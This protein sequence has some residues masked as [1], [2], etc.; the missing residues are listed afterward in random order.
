MSKGKL[1]ITRMEKNVLSLLFGNDGELMQIY[2]DGGRY[3]SL[4]GNIYVGR[5]SNIVESINGAFVE[6]AHEKTGY[7]ALEDEKNPIFTDINRKEA[8]I[9]NG[10][11][12]I[13]Q[14]TKDAAGNKEPVVS[15]N[16]TLTG[17]YVV[18]STA[19]TG[20][21]FSSKFRNK[22]KIEKI[23][24]KYEELG[25]DGFGFIIRTNAAK[26][27]MDSIFEEIDLY[28]QLWKA[29]RD[30]AFGKKGIGQIYSSPK[31]YIASIRDGYDDDVSSII[32]DNARIYQEI[33]DYLSVYQTDDIDKLSLYDNP[34]VSLDALYS[35]SSH[36]ND[37]LKER[38]WLKSGGYLIIQPTEAFVSIDVNTGKYVSKKDSQKEFL[39]INLEAAEEIAKQIRLRNLSGIIIIDFINMKSKE[40]RDQLMKEFDALLKKDPQKT[41]LV[42]MTKLNLVEI[43]RKKERRPL[44]E[45]LDI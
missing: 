14:V 42:E 37:A 21:H 2:C 32:T 12:L 19:S 26:A 34:Y 20:L 16:I 13:V 27:P 43:T 5:V 15:T 9:K 4:V 3:E 45:L 25:I 30:C 8:P 38:V 11:T 35:I 41:T 29:L 6:F 18:L 33:Y 23:R 44:Y 39:K 7:M 40:R 36:I 22:E 28:S 31:S 24:A 1:V 10:D 17:K